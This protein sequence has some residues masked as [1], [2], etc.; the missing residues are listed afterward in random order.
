[1]IL[2]S[3]LTKEKSAKKIKDDLKK[4]GQT[5]KKLF[6]DEFS[7]NSTSDEVQDQN[8]QFELEDDGLGNKPENQPSLKQEPTQ[9]KPKKKKKKQGLFSTEPEEQETEGSF[10]IEFEP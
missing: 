9:E 6:Q 4:E 1:M 2:R 10:E 3:V 8:I 7:G 5:I